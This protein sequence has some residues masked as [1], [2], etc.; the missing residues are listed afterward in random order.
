MKANKFSLFTV[1]IL[2]YSINCAYRIIDKEE[3]YTTQKSVKKGAA[4]YNEVID[5]LKQIL[6]YYVYIDLLKNPPQPSFDDNY[7]T[8]VNTFE[9]LEEIRETITEDTNY[10]DFYRSLKYF[11]DSYADAH[12]SY[13]LRG[14]SFNYVFL[15]PLKLSTV[16]D[17]NGTFVMKGEIAFN[18]ETYFRNGAE[19]FNII[20]QNKD[21][22]IE[23]I[24][25][26]T[27]FEF[28]QTFGGDFFNLKNKQ[29]TYAFKTHNYMAPYAIYFPFDSDEIGFKVEY[30]NG[31]WF[32]TEYAIAEIVNDFEETGNNKIYNFYN[33]LNTEK[34]FMNFMDNYF[35]NNNINEK[36]TSLAE[37]LYQFE[38]SKNIIYQNNL[39]NNKNIVFNKDNILS[40]NDASKIQ[41]DYEYIQGNSKTFQCRVDKDNLL[42]VIHMP[43]FDFGDV[44]KIRGLI[45]DCVKL[46]DT[47]TYQIVVILNYNGGGVELVAQTTIEY[48][49]PYISSSFY[50]T[51]RQGKYLD[52]YYDIDN[53]VDH[54]VV[55]TCKIPDKKYVLE[56]FKLIDYGDDVINNVTYPLRRFGQYRKEF[57]EVKKSL[58]NKRKPTEILIFTDGYSASSASLFTK[59]LQNEGG[60]IIAGY[61]G[62]PA[63]SDVF[64]SSQHFSSVF[65][66]ND[67][68]ILEKDL[69]EKMQKTG[70][71]FS[72]ICGTGNFFDYNELKI[73]EEF[74]IKQLD[75]VTEIFEEYNEDKNYNLFMETA[76]NIFLKYKNQCNKNNNKITLFDQ[77]CV[78]E[79]DK[80]AHGG[81]PC[82]QDG[83]WDLTKCSKAYCK[84]GYLLDYKANKCVRDPCSDKSTDNFELVKVNVF[85]LILLLMISAL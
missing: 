62:N 43:T 80:H 44:P 69:T 36:P 66:R 41:W 83:K 28:M 3:F 63:S 56:N 52:K 64:D 29:A 15:C 10:Y 9:R 31:A 78:F 19:I 55:E 6:K 38:K 30:T 57:D 71:F 14:F 26:K 7:F 23:K 1:L 24:N 27:P 5:N 25:G 18:D 39:M 82:G 76:K 53:F 65:K 4:F 67:L 54:S 59:S 75:E 32:E 84:E 33:D 79:D 8:K 48:I 11:I 13:G 46:F 21:V 74:N 22:S 72:Q 77:K 16:K 2:I 58:K 50:S 61:N 47:N 37:L 70:I 34:D 42:N 17:D 12:M 51:F 20:S 45:K 60:A 40:E 35:K 49:Q 85:L 73:P 68:S 81:H